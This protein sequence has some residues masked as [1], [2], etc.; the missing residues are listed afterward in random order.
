SIKQVPLIQ[1]EQHKD[2]NVKSGTSVTVHWPGLSRS[3]LENAKQRFLQ[4][5]TDY[6][7][8]NPHLTLTVDWCG[9]GTTTDATTKNWGKWLPSDPTSAHWYNREK[10]ERLISANLAHDANTGHERT[11]REIISEFDGLTGTAKQKILLDQLGL[12][13]AGL[14]V[15]RNGDG[16]DHQ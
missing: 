1:H 15:L 12:H 7:F 2:R 8:L 16:L 5:A 10:F 3:I 6:T 4:I 14:S 13:R 9:E 11:V